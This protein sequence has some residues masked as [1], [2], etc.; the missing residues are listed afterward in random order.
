MTNSLKTLSTVGEQ[1]A[2]SVLYLK[3][4][5]D[6]A[7]QVLAD[8]DWHKTYWG[9]RALFNVLETQGL[10]HFNNGL[11]REG[12]KQAQSQPVLSAKQT[13]VIKLI[14]ESLGVHKSEILH[15]SV[16]TD[17]LG[18]DSLD[19]IEIIMALEQKFN[20]EVPDEQAENVRTVQDLYDL[21][22]K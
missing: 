12:P 17:D 8:T 2:T 7:V 3:Q 11:I 16:L 13:R 9:Q 19:H 21:V 15:T 1:V 5:E 4:L 20:F 22:D 6:A 14:S 10:V 18:A